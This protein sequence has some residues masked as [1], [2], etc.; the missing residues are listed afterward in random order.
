MSFVSFPKRVQKLEEIKPIHANPLKESLNIL[1]D[2]IK[3]VGLNPLMSKEEKYSQI[4][5]LRKRI[6]LRE[7]VEPDAS[8]P[9]VKGTSC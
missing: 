4:T 7:F 2:K 9:M 3:C 8:P 6:L 1:F 5:E